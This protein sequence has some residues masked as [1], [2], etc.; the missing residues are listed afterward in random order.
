MKLFLLIWWIAICLP[1]AAQESSFTKTNLPD[2]SS[3][4]IPNSWK[5]TTKFNQNMDEQMEALL[6]G[7]DPRKLNLNPAQNKVQFLAAGRFNNKKASVMAVFI[8]TKDFGQNEMA[9]LSEA[10]KNAV[11]QQLEQALTSMFKVKPKI[12][13]E[14]I[15]DHHVIYS[16]AAFPAENRLLKIYQIPTGEKIVQFQFICTPDMNEIW[17][18][19]FLK[20]VRS[21]TF[22]K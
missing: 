9:R 12:A 15:G 5:S 6:D 22:K 14:K 17:N 4:E 18:P 16:E 11:I 7:V 2:A 1:A 19:I 8:D 20:I 10:E 3:V 13:F 21:Y